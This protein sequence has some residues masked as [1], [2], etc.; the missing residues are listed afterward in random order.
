MDLQDGELI[1]GV[2]GTL[3]STIREVKSRAY[4]KRA[5]RLSRLRRVAIPSLSEAEFATQ[6]RGVRPCAELMGEIFDTLRIVFIVGVILKR[7]SFFL[8]VEAEYSDIVATFR[9]DFFLGSTPGCV[10]VSGVSLVVVVLEF[11]G[12]G[13]NVVSSV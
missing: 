7:L 11:I 4:R 1:L 9:F 10:I 6:F 12:E 5:E 3:Q 13:V 8:F 2:S